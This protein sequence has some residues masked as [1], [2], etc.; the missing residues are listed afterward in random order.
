MSAIELG[1]CV[2]R[3]L[4]L[5]VLA[6]CEDEERHEGAEDPE[7]RHPPDMPDQG[8]ADDHGEEGVDDAGRSVFRHF[9]RLVPASL[10]WLTL[11]YA[12]ERLR[13]PVGVSSGDA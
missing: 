1:Q 8:K 3:D 4:N 11:A 12:R 2:N 5:L 9:D 10:R 7:S 6:K 13:R